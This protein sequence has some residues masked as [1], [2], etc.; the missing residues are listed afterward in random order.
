MSE[1]EDLADLAWSTPEELQRS[2]IEILR[3][4][5]GDIELSPD[6]LQAEIRAHFERGLSPKPQPAASGFPEVDLTDFK[7]TR[8]IWNG[9]I[10]RTGDGDAGGFTLSCPR[11]GHPS[12][13]LLHCGQTD[14]LPAGAVRQN[15]FNQRSAIA[16]C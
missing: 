6:V 10:I 13:A 1:T 14:A 2:I 7:N 12:P 11:P 8:S 3:R 5:Y 4:R 15:K 16:L 9:V